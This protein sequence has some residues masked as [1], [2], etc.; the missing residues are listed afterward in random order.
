MKKK[1]RTIAQ[2]ADDL[3]AALKRE[4]ADVVAIGGLLIEAQDQLDHG[5][6]LPWLEANFG[7][8]VRTADNYMNAARFASK[9]ETVSNLKLRPTALYLLGSKLDDGPDDLFSPKA[10]KAILKVAE[11]EWVN[12]KRAQAIAES[13]RPPPKIDDEEE[14]EERASEV[15]ERVISD[16]EIENILEGPPPLPPPEPPPASN[17]SLGQFDKAVAMLAQVHTKPLASFVGTEQS[18]DLIRSLG[19]FLVAVA[20]ANAKRRAA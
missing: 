14:E 19:D 17:V 1:R 4:L 6:W 3:A 20:D 18:P 8:S 7:S 15:E 2:I 12:A 13:L 11:D 10:I 16:E 5:Q 9:L